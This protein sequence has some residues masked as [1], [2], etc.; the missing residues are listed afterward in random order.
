MTGGM[1]YLAL[2]TLREARIRRI[3]LEA[4]A[5]E[6]NLPF[7]LQ[8]RAR[9]KLPPNVLRLNG[10]GEHDPPSRSPLGLISFH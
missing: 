9:G 5:R 8:A 4:Q 6:P 2:A 3:L 1:L 7:A 10:L